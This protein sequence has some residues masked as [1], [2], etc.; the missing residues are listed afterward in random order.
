[1]DE[2]IIEEFNEKFDSYRE[3]LDYIADSQ[4][5]SE[6]IRKRDFVEIRNT[7]KRIAERQDQMQ[8]QSA[9]SEKR[10]DARANQTQKH[11]D[12][13]TKVVRFLVEE[14]EFQD[15]KLD[16]AGKVLSRKRKK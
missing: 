11:L 6:F 13:I 7:L 1:M 14:N 8:E 16:E 15:E 9:E 5:K 2:E 4:A 3:A 12:Y 10:M